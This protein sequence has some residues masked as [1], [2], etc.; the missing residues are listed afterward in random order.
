MTSLVT[1]ATNQIRI[2][3]SPERL[4]VAVEAGGAVLAGAA[5]GGLVAVGQWYA[6]LGLILALILGLLGVLLLRRHRLAVIILWLLVAP[7]VVETNSALLRKL[8]WL[9]HRGLPVAVLG[10]M[11]L[12][13]L[14]G[15]RHRSSRLGWPETLMGGYVLASLLSIFYTS[16]DPMATAVLFYDRVVIPMCLYLI[17][18]LVEPDESELRQLV[19]VGVFILVTQSA[20]GV[21]QWI[22]PQLLPSA[23]LG[24]E[25]ARTTGSLVHP[26]VFATTLLFCGLLSLHSALS[27]SRP[28]SSRRGLMIL[29]LLAIVMAFLTFSRASWLAASVMIGGLLFV[30]PRA[31]RRL[32]LIAVS[33]VG[34][35]L[36]AGFLSGIGNFAADR[37]DSPSSEQSALSRLPVAVASVRMF[38]E[39]P[40]FGWGYENF[41]KF[42]RQFQ[43]TV[44]GFYPDKD[45]SHHNLFLT[46]LAEQGLL[47]LLLYVGPTVW[48]LALTPSALANMPQQGFLSRRLLIILW[49]IAGSF[50]IVNLF[51]NFRVTF[52]FGMWWITLGLIGSLVDRYHP[53]RKQPDDNPHQ[54]A[55]IATGLYALEEN[56]TER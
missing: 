8:F 49:L 29:F 45:Q 38:A 34:L 27:V 19:P 42:D 47:G 4:R 9:I 17:I 44:A 23:W 24:L 50:F 54:S 5:I 21:L 2:W 52:G 31:L 40:L 10:V 15:D 41:D 55:V 14:V 20:L 30:Y 53:R 36:V 35:L 6:A 37:F 16:D 7:F 28:V 32:A 25:G 11:V 46:L 43:T 26:N 13:I 39:R 48:W 12:G 33:I 3:V 1:D 22:A 56:A 18:R 51:S